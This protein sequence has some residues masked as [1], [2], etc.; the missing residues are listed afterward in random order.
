RERRWPDLDFHMSFVVTEATAH[1]AAAFAEYWRDTGVSQVWLHNMTNRAGLIAEA[2]RP[3]DMTPFAERFANDPLVRVDLFPETDGPA[4]L[5]RVARGID[6]V[7]VD[8]DMLLCAQD[9]EGRHKFGNITEGSLAQ[10]HHGKILRHLRGE[11]CD[12]CAGCTFCPP[13]F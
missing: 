4:N 10:L 12:T 7:S 8:G 1:E 5:C 11:T 2:C 13:S 6:F 3:A 9:Y